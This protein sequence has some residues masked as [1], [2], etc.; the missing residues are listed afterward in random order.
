[1]CRC[2]CVNVMNRALHFASG[3]RV[4]N[5]VHFSNLLLVLLLRRSEKSA[6]ADMVLKCT[7]FTNTDEWPAFSWLLL[8][9]SAH[10]FGS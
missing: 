7:N 5:S 4:S 10:G 9:A 6:T 2:G 1:M 3:P 8:P